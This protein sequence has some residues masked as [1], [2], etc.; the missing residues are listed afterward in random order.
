MANFT[1]AQ[2]DETLDGITGVA[3][4]TTPVTTYLA[5]FSADPT[6]TGSVTNELTGGGYARLSLAGL[7]PASTGT[8]T[9]SNDVVVNFATATA[10][11]SQATHVGIMKSGVATTDDMMVHIQLDSPISLL[12]TQVFSF[13]IGDLTINAN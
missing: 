5:I 3:Q 6:E 1:N 9:V 11:W 12:N 8:G 2:E 4:Q 13:A 7:F 10:D